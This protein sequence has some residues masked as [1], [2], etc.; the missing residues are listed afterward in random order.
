MGDA[1][2]ELLSLNHATALLRVEPNATC[3]P[4]L[5]S[6]F[7]ALQLTTICTIVCLM[8]VWGCLRFG[9][10]ELCTR[11]VRLVILAVAPQAPDEHAGKAI[12]L[13]QDKN[14]DKKAGAIQ[15]YER[16]SPS[17]KARAAKGYVSP[18]L[19][20]HSRLASPSGPKTQPRQ[21][22]TPVKDR[23][24]GG[25]GSG[26]P[27]PPQ[28]E[29]QMDVWSDDDTDSEDEW[30]EDRAP[31]YEDPMC[32]DTTGTTP[33]RQLVLPSPVMNTANQGKIGRSICEIPWDAEEDW[34]VGQLT[35][36]KLHM[37]EDPRP[38]RI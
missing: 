4:H 28:V 6:T 20:P 30:E 17:M 13:E 19:G 23:G 10:V 5:D 14:G 15:R 12:L 25:K 18:H 35:A 29:Q 34:V 33:D 24:V 8:V 37:P 11:L 1:G 31:W 26:L 9:G 7:D 3:S 38:R 36:R 22:K 2:G 21:A 32:R 27:L 16:G